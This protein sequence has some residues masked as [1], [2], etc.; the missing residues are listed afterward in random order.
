MIKSIHARNN[1]S[2]TPLLFMR[3][4]FRKLKWKHHLIF[5]IGINLSAFG[6]LRGGEGLDPEYPF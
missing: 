2:Q 3:T 5:V 1:V 4:T 6:V